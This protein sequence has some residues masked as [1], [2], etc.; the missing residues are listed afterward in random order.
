MS[1]W[2]ILTL[3]ISLFAEADV[4]SLIGLDSPTR[5]HPALLAGGE[6]AVLPSVISADDEPQQSSQSQAKSNAEPLQE[7]NKLELIRYVSGEFAKATKP[8]PGGKDGFYLNAGEP[9]DTELLN[10]AVATRGAAVHTGD[11]VQITKLEFRDHTVVV[12]LNGGGRPKKHWRDRVQVSMGGGIPTARTT[13]TQQENGPPGMQPGAGTTIFLEFKKHVPNLTPDELKQC[14]SPF[15]DFSKQRSA[16]VHWVDTLP[17]EM[18]KA[19]EERRPLV[20]MD[21]EEVIAAIG[22]PDHKVRERDPEGQ[23][24]EDW[25]YGQP[26]AKTIFIRFLGDR[27]TT[28]RQF[29]Q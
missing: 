24:I 27:V 13:T 26:P 5:G 21:R 11:T 22:R 9:V 18:K 17:P 29:P 15:L 2:L 20:G 19:I 1:N 7:R 28:I 4:P 14:L 16:S 10:R 23:E 6:I 12:D 25:I 3:A 8:L